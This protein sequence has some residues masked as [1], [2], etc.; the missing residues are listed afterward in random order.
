MGGGVSAPSVNRLRKTIV[1]RAYNL[2][3]KD[4]T[5][6]EQ[7]RPFA[8]RSTSTNKLCLSLIDVKSSLQLE[9]GS[10]WTSIENLLV[11]CVG[12]AVRLDGIDYDVFIAFLES[13]KMPLQKLS[14]S[15]SAGNVLIEKV[16]VDATIAS[17]KG[18]AGQTLPSPPPAMKTHKPDLR[19]DIVR[20]NDASPTPSSKPED[21]NSAPMASP[22]PYLVEPADSPEAQQHT[23]GQQVFFAAER[24]T[25]ENALVL[26]SGKG[27]SGNALHTQSGKPLWK[28]KETTKV[29]RT[30]E[31]TTIDADGVLQEL[32]EQEITETEVLHMEC[33]E[34]GEFAHR[35]TTEFQQKEVFN[36][37]V[38]SEQAGTEEYV[39]L[40]SLD[41][42]IEYMDS[43]MPQKQSQQQEPEREREDAERAAAAAE[44]DRTADGGSYDHEETYEEY[45]YRQAM[46]DAQSEAAAAAA[47]MGDDEDEF[48][49]VR[50]PPPNVRPAPPRRP[51]QDMGD[52]C[53]DEDGQECPPSSSGRGRNPA[54][55]SISTK[56]AEGC[57]DDLDDADDTAAGLRSDVDDDSDEARLNQ[58]YQQQ[59]QQQQRQR[60]RMHLFDPASPSSSQ[61]Q[62]RGDGTGD[63]KDVDDDSRRDQGATQQDA[64][65]GEGSDGPDRRGSMMDI[66]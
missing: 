4:E 22:H 3:K 24:K 55:P 36:K 15:A 50:N 33:K 9:D 61:S 2:R 10:L 43:T 1:I 54:G 28:K 21:S 65:A 44:G 25:E 42:E 14:A 13:G 40:K 23:K 5:L 17:I 52:G 51:P 18:K 38:V 32:F 19:V 47:G 26:V 63:V 11:H 46:A 56:T 12:P 49:Q 64:A 62:S 58:H 34:T 29:E 30:I 57:G 66:D 6:D 45:L 41:D 27:S 35:E 59:Q 48:P 60:Q 39:H 31:Y 7:L 37:E 53:Y 8:T 16:N 20:D